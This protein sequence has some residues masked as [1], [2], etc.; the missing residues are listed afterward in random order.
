MDNIRFIELNHNLAAVFTDVSRNVFDETD[1]K[2]VDVV[3]GKRGYVPWGESNDLPD[4][5]LEKIRKNDVM[6]PNMG[7][8]IFCGYGAGLKVSMPEGQK[9]PDEPKKFFRENNMVSLL[10]EQQ[11]DLKHF[12]FAVGL[13]TLSNDG[14]KIVRYHHK[15][16]LH[17]R[18]ETC[19]ETNGKIEHV[20]F[21]N[22]ADNP[23]DKEVDFFP[24]LDKDY[25]L[26]DLLV[27]MGREI[28]P[29]T[30]KKE[31][32]TKDR[33]FAVVI[34]IPIPGRK[35][36]SFPYY[37]AS[38]YSGWYDIMSMIPEAKRA[39]M[40]N[41]MSIKYQVEINRRFWEDLFAEKKIVG[42][43][44][45]KAAREKVYTEISTFINGVENQG[46]VWYSGFWVDNNGHEQ[47][48]VKINV[49]DPHKEGGDYIEDAEEASNMIC[50]A[51]GVHP[52]LIGATPGK[53][54]GSLSGTDKRE[55]FTMKQALERSTRDMQL[56][57]FE[58]IAGYNGWDEALELDIPDLMLTTLDQ[59]TDAKTA[60]S[61][62]KEPEK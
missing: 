38:F 3:D 18:F 41:G 30:G 46:K 59:G 9:I 24:V 12:F 10:L 2:P 40:K 48:D 14:K 20:F 28:N 16:A 37:W 52:S 56:Q 43:K 61:N 27:R 8:N 36:Y 50:Y 17:C 31:T 15:E 55:L 1:A 51:Q 44:D 6:S 39:K 22:W 13:L 49:V 42:E 47:K 26:G 62:P 58:I 5:I 23:S 25:P 4:Q 29:N 34:R 21:A 7:F 32:Q 11:T 60:T 33:Q 19:N 54:K 53:A 45:R 35:Y 57:V